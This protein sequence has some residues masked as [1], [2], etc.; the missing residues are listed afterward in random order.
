LRKKIKWT[1][2]KP[3]LSCEAYII[4]RI[5]ANQKKLRTGGQMTRREAI[6]RLKGI[7]IHADAGDKQ[8]LDRAL[9]DMTNFYLYDGTLSMHEESHEGDA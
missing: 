8:A 4:A 3:R 1:K 2:R 5:A 6:A 9:E 7:R